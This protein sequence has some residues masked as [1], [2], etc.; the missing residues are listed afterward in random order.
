MNAY[1]CIYSEV[2]RKLGT[3]TYGQLIER[4]RKFD[5]FV[6]AVAFSRMISNTNINMVGKPIIDIEE[7]SK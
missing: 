5:T 1:K 4:T 2:N 6:E 7:L 3:K